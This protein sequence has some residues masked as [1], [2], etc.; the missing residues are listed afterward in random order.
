MYSIHTDKT[1]ENKNHSVSN[2]AFKMHS[3]S[4]STMQFV[5]NRPEAI[6]QR[7]LTEGANYSSQAIQVAQLQAK[8]DNKSIQQH[9]PI[10]KKEN[11]TGLPDNLKSGIENIS[12]YSMDDVKVHYNSSK[13]AQLQAHAYAQGS[14]IHLSSGQ[15][16]HLP[17]EA[18]HV[19]QQKQGRVKPTMQMKG[20]VNINDD[21]GLEKEADK[22]GE[23][24]VQMKTSD[25]NRQYNLRTKTPSGG[26]LPVQRAHIVEGPGIFKSVVGIAHWEIIIWDE[27]K[28]L[29][30]RYGAALVPNPGIGDLVSAI[31]GI[32][33]GFNAGDS[34]VWSLT[35]QDCGNDRVAGPTT[36]DWT[37]TSNSSP[38]YN[39][40]LNPDQA[41]LAKERIAL[42]IAKQLSN[43]PIEFNQ[44]TNTCRAFALAVFEAANKG[45]STTKGKLATIGGGLNFRTEE[46]SESVSKA[47]VMSGAIDY[48]DPESV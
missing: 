22:M 47:Q 45:I 33:P 39:P 29:W 8:G 4:R 40:K 48:S 10:Q 6:L 41:F 16:K 17:H 9:E 43:D 27:S 36:G 32:I 37:Y 25:E 7:K 12:G 20:K 1:Q 15:E 14:Q 21:T 23:Q 35:R 31:P 11:N 3:D 46:A 34:V 13:P 26:G 2:S 42:A 38:N 19:V 18:W 30:A 5:N 44:I 24:A 28:N